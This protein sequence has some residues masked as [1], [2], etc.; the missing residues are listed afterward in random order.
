MVPAVVARTLT[1]PVV[2]LALTFVL[3]LTALYSWASPLAHEAS[4]LLHEKMPW[5]NAPFFLARAGIVL[6]LFVALA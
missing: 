5:L 4:H 1:V 3:G 2:A 6:V